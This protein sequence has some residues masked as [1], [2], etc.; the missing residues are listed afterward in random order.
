MALVVEDGTGLPNAESLVSVA[1]ADAYQA[2]RGFPLWATLTLERKE[3]LLRRA[4]DYLNSVY[5]GAFSGS[6][7]KVDQAFHFPAIV[8]GQLVL[9]PIPVKAS[10]C[11]LAL[12]A[13]TQDLQPNIKRGKKK[14]KLGPLEVEY[15]GNSPMQTIFVSASMKLKPFLNGVVASSNHVKLIRT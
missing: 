9:T 15:D 13:E 4:C 11:E 2:S 5:Y 6:R 1:E 8:N 3:I 12:I 10:I 14:V 7:L